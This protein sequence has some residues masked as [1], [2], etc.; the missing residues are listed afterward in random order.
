VTKGILL[1]I[2]ELGFNPFVLEKE[3]TLE[4]TIALKINLI[5]NLSKLDFKFFN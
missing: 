3:K 1:E 4:L 2:D 5:F